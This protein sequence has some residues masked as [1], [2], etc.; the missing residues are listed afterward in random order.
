M[1]HSKSDLQQ[2]KKEEGRFSFHHLSH[3][4]KPTQF[5]GEDYAF[6]FFLSN[7]CEFIVGERAASI[8]PPDLAG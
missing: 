1:K 4:S 2:D 6:C 7:E 3:H 5:F 8:P